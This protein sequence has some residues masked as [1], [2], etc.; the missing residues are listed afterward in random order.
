MQ[1]EMRHAA[2]LNAG[3]LNRAVITRNDCEAALQFACDLL[4]E[5]TRKRLLA[6]HSTAGSFVRNKPENSLKRAR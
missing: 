5:P 3:L 2:Q 1:G 6:N 4:Y